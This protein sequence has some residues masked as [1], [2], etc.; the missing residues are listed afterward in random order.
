[1]R[2][3]KFIPRVR[4]EAYVDLTRRPDT[5]RFYRSMPKKHTDVLWLGNWGDPKSVT[6]ELSDFVI[7]TAAMMRNHVFAAWECAIRWCA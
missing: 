7:T 2:C 4:S 6:Q 3:S 1:M 5:A